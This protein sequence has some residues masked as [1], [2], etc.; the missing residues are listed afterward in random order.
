[1]KREMKGKAIKERREKMQVKLK[2]MV[3]SVMSTRFTE[4]N[5]GNVLLMS[6]LYFYDEQFGELLANNHLTRQQQKPM[7]IPVNKTEGGS[8]SN[9]KAADNSTLL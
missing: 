3:Q 2:K 5:G 4:K 8:T 6:I 7:I 9:Q 1:M